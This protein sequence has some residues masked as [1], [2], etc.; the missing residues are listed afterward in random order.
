MGDCCVKSRE[1]LMPDPDT[2]GSETACGKSSALSFR[3]QLGWGP[4]SPS[5][6]PSL[7]TRFPFQ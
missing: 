6:Q 7:R 3:N 4:P 2:S 5:T 1:T